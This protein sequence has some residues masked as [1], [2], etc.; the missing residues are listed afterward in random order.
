M[1]TISISILVLKI[2][3]TNMI[4]YIQKGYEKVPKTND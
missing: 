2:I 3:A 1:T 4:I